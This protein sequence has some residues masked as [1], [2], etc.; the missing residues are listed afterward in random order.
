MFVH[1]ANFHQRNSAT[2]T[3]ARKDRYVAEVLPVNAGFFP[4]NGEMGEDKGYWK[5]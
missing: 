2:M 4:V 5:I 1:V 3:V